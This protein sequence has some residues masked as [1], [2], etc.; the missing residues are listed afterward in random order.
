MLNE[1]GLLDETF[2]AYGDDADLGLKGRFRGYSAW[3]CP[4]A[5]ALHKYSQTTGAYS[6]TKGFLV[7]RNRLWVMLKYFPLPEILASPWFTLQRYLLQAWGARRRQG[8]AG[9]LAAAA[10]FHTL[11]GITLKAYLAAF[12]GLPRVLRERRRLH[13]QRRVSSRQFRSWLK[14]YAISARELALK[15]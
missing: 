7:E 2:F 6:P 9:R 14:T 13:R 10:G 15:D 8:A 4:G 5:R 11:I 1:T 3:Y 12:R